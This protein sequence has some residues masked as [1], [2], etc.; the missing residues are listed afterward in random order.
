MEYLL[1]RLIC[2][3]DTVFY[4]VKHQCDNFAGAEHFYDVPS[5]AFSNIQAM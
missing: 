5:E 4:D 2:L 3:S 1:F